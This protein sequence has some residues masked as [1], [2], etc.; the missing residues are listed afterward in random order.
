MPSARSL[1]QDIEKAGTL[2][3]AEVRQAVL[4]NEFY[5][6]MGKVKC[7]KNLGREKVKKGGYVCVTWMIPSII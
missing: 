4:D 3:S 7:D 2:D 5:T 1:C 6:M